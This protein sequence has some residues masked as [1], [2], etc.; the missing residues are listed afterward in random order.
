MIEQEAEPKYVDESISGKDLLTLLQSRKFVQHFLKA[1]KTT[2]LSG[3]ES[4]F[5]VFKVFG[6]NSLAFSD[7]TP[8][9]PNSWP[10]DFH[11]P[12]REG[13][14][15]NYPLLVVHTHPEAEPVPTHVGR[16]G[17][18]DHGPT[19]E[20]LEG[21]VEIDTKHPFR[22]YGLVVSVNKD[23]GRIGYPVTMWRNDYTLALVGPRIKPVLSLK[24]RFRKKLGLPVSFDDDIS[25]AI[26]AERSYERWGKQL[27]AL[28]FAGSFYKISSLTSIEDLT[29]RRLNKL[30]SRGRVGVFNNNIPSPEPKISFI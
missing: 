3:N 12:S 6:E 25:Q 19:L 26:Y 22:T 14:P 28:W 16:N 20:A 5:C 27:I 8:G 21:D 9:T 13:L 4:G 23:N 15:A 10:I 29:A 30:A 7:V 1:I 11:S 18:T 24:E 2:K 17:G